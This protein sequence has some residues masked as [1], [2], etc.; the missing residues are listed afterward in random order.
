MDN[1]ILDMRVDEFLIITAVTLERYLAIYFSPKSAAWRTIK[2]AKVQ[3]FQYLDLQ[4]FLLEG[5]CTVT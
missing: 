2:R 5:T 3:L 1:L 4:T